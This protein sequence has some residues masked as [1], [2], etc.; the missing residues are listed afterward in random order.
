MSDENLR[1]FDH[2]D[3]DDAWRLGSRLV[4]R[5]RA[6]G[7]PVVVSIHIGEQRV[8]HAGLPG[9]SASNDAWVDRKRNIVRRFDRS[10][11]AVYERYAAQL[12]NF[13]EVFALPPTEFA[14]GE[15]AVPIR[16]HGTQVGV[17]SVS[18]I[19]PTGDHALVLQALNEGI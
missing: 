17:L 12:P 8:F 16:V 9:S 18:G 19:E 14:A 6:A 4:E 3:H 7:L 1:D 11:L 5:C 13:Y 10:S 15:G 2:F